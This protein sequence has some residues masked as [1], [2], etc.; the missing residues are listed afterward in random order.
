MITSAI[1]IPIATPLVTS[2]VGIFLVVLSLILFAPMLLTRIRI[3]HVIGLIIAGVAVGPYGF[4]VLSRDMSFEVFGQVGL[5]YL[6]FLAG[7]EID[8]YHLKKNLRRGLIFGLYTFF[9]PLIVGAL[10][11]IYL[12]G[13]KGVSSLMLASMFAAHTL[14]AYPIVSRFGLQKNP[15][16]VIAIAGTIFTVL[17]SL[18]VLAASLGIE[19]EGEFSFSMLLRLAGS[20][21]LYCGAIAYIFPRLTRW[22]FRKYNDGVMQFIYVLAMMFLSA[23]AA[24]AIDI[25]GVF[26][27]F[28]AGIVLNRFIPVRS[29]LMSRIEFVGNAIFIP[30]FLIGVGMLI[31]V[32]VLTSGWNTVYVAAVMSAVAMFGKWL[33]AFLTQRTFGM[34]SADRSMLY[35]LSNAHTAVALAVVTIGFNVGVFDEHILNGTIL[36]IL[37][38]CTVSSIGTS[39]AAQR[40]KVMSLGEISEVEKEVKREKGIRTLIPVVNPVTANELV[41][42]AMLMNDGN[43]LRNKMYALHVRNDNMPASRAAGKNSLDV[44]VHVASAMDFQLKSIDRYDLNFVTGVLNTIEERDI[45]E[46]VIGLHRRST[47]IDSFF[48]EK[49][50]QL[51]KATF[52]MVVISRCFIPVNTMRRIVVFVPDKAQFE[53]GFSHWV[54]SIGNL[55]RQLGCRVIFY[56]SAETRKYISTVLRVGRYEIRSEYRLTEEWDDLV[57][58]SNKIRTDDLFV[59][60]SARRTSVSFTSDMDTLPEFLRKYFSQNNLLVIY[61]EQFGDEVPVMAVADT[62]SADVEAAPISLWLKLKTAYRSRRAGR[63]HSGPEGDERDTDF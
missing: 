30:Y 42:L 39:R 13:L 4:N 46:V 56:S 50:T 5:L 24:I 23:Q 43:K 32:R 2:P 41:S 29:P 47:V 44:A 3:P 58:L 11:A 18:M 21:V 48:G 61:P 17:G 52:R 60:V 25:E 26:G 54:K 55:T 22:F 45:N 63:K 36:M 7:V 12:L 51:L 62:M 57:L 10:A 40:L 19:R 38:T 9:V 28:Y 8:M 27:A 14:L 33:A 59:V 53:T 31:N 37:I 6:M 34:R 15:A 20:L 16:V 49:L 35:Q 1:T